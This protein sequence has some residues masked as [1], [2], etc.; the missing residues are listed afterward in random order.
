MTPT[1]VADVF[2]ASCGA[3]AR[4]PG[5]PVF[6]G[7]GCCVHPSVAAVH[8]HEVGRRGAAAA[9]HEHMAGRAGP[10]AVAFL[11]TLRESGEL[12]GERPRS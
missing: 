2:C 4:R 6:H 7:P 10:D 5:E 11:L 3:T 1:I 9:R 12:D 8:L